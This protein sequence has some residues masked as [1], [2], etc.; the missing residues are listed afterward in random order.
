[1]TAA[2]ATELA[3]SWLA[4]LAAIAALLSPRVSRWSWGAAGLLDSA[5][6]ALMAS[7]GIGLSLAAG[8][9]IAMFVEADGGLAQ[10]DF[11][12]VT[13]RLGLLL[14]GILV[15][16][17]VMVRGAQVNAADAPH[18]FP[19]LAAGMVALIALLAAVENAEIHRAARLL[20]VL[21]AVAWTIATGGTEPAVAIVA[22]AAMPVLALTGRLGR[23][24]ESRT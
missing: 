1:V 18:V 11:A 9:L 23:F 21:A 7:P 6:L 19:M 10:L 16:V 4:L 24:G 20:L 5:S 3:L 12:L 8:C 17:V 14:A 13:R 2:Q 15:A 22:G